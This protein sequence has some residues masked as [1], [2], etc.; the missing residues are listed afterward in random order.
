MSSLSVDSLGKITFGANG[1]FFRVSQDGEI[2]EVDTLHK[3]SL[4]CRWG[5]DLLVAE[6]RFFGNASIE[7]VAINDDVFEIKL[8][9]KANAFSST[10][11][12]V[13]WRGDLY[14]SI[15]SGH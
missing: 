2:V 5:K 8:E 12:L 9:N 7:Q 4:G 10:L 13:E 1:I 6:G 14:I 11:D 15:S 3:S